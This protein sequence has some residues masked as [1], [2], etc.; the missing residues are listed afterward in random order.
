MKKKMKDI[1]EHLRLA[2]R[3]RK[4]LQMHQADNKLDRLRGEWA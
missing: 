1:S 4:L 2:K 3:K